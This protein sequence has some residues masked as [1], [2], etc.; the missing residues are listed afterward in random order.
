MQNKNCEKEFQKKNVYLIWILPIILIFLT[1]FAITLLVFAGWLRYS[2]FSI[3]QSAQTQFKGNCVESL[4]KVINDES[5]S[6][7]SRN[8]AVWAVGQLAR[9]EALPTL[10]THYTGVTSAR[11]PL[12]STLSQYELAKAIHWCENGNGT[13]WLYWGIE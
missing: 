8:D 5:Q 12:D 4:S 2:V 13:S 3:C 1:L 9:P 6:F 7:R 11:E 10:K